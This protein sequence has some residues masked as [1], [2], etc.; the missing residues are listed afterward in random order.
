MAVESGLPPATAHLAQ[1]VTPEDLEDV[2]IEL[3]ETLKDVIHTSVREACNEIDMTVSMAL[4]MLPV[5]LRQ[6][7]LERACSIGLSG[8]P[9]KIDISQA[10]GGPKQDDSE[11][12]LKRRLEEFQQKVDE[13]E[14]DWETLR[15]QNEQ[16]TH[17]LAFGKAT[18]TMVAGG[19]GI[20]PMYQALL[21][22]L[23]TPGD[24]SK[25]RLLYGNR[26]ENDILL[27][28][29][30]D[31]LA[32][33]HADR[34]EIRYVIGESADDISA[35]S[36]GWQGALGWV[37]EKK[38]EKFAFPPASDTVVWVCGVDDM[39]KSLAGGRLTKG[40]KAGSALQNLGY[41]EDMVWR[42]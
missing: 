9:D 19:T 23:N 33:A 8:Q 35:A 39:Y 2:A 36:R 42:S 10:A 41:T 13:V 12:A 4:R 26:H 38:L 17:A 15:N 29:E 7:S 20:A 37:D 14:G 21:P 27:K 1:K 6:M 11:E 18:I 24:D 22:L 32:A 25:V 30:L 5:D 31:E 40:L 34:F 16:S 28:K 3:K